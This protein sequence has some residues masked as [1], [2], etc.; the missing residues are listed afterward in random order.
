MVDL[1]VPRD[2]EP[3]VGDLADVYLYT[4]D[5]LEDVI[6][7]S[8]RSRQEAADEAEQIIELQVNDF[9]RWLRAQNLLGTLKTYRDSSCEIRDEVLTKAQRMIAAGRPPEE[10]LEFLA[11]TLTNKLIHHPTVQLN[12]AAHDGREEVLLFAR[13]LLGLPKD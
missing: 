7:E 11:N 12:K 8:R 10:A 13:E 2:I 4:V 9:T 6:E 1:A 5:D 3:E